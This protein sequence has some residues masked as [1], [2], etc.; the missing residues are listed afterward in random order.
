MAAIW[1]PIPGRL[2]SVS[3]ADKDNIWGV[4]LDLQL[5]KFNSK[6][7][8]WQLVSVTTEKINR[9]RFSSSSAQS[10]ASTTSSSFNTAKKFASYLP[11]LGLTSTTTPVSSPPATTTAV[12]TAQKTHQRNASTGSTAPGTPAT[13]TRANSSRS[14]LGTDT[15]EDTTIRVSAA[16]DGTV[17]RLD[18]SLKAWYLIA[19]HNDYVDYEKDVIWIDLGHFWK[20]VSGDIYYGTSGCFA[21]LEH[22]ITSGAGYSKPAFTHISVGNDNVVL[23]TDAHTGTVFRLK[24]HPTGSCPPVWTALTGTGPGSSLHILNCSISTT[25][26]IV[27]VAKDGRVYRYS[28]SVWTPLGGGAKL[29]NVG[30]GIDGYVLGVDRD[31][32]LFGCQLESIA[33]T[34]PPLN[35]DRPSS[36]EWTYK[37]VRDDQPTTPSSPQAPN[38]PSLF[39][40]PRQQGMSKRPTFSPRELFE[41]AASSTLGSPAAA[42][43][44]DRSPGAGEL[45]VDTTSKNRAPSPLGEVGRGPSWAQSHPHVFAKGPG[46]DRSD[47]R[48]SKRSYASDITI[49]KTPTGLSLSR[50]STPVSFRVPENDIS[51]S[52]T[53]QPTTTTTTT[54]ITPEAAL[55]VLNQSRA[56]AS[57]LRILTK[58]MPISSAASLSTGHES[59]SYFTSKPITIIGPSSNLSPMTSFPLDGNPYATGSKPSSGHSTAQ[60]PVTPHSSDSYNNNNAILSVSSKSSDSSR[61]WTILGQQTVSPEETRALRQAEQEEGVSRAGNEPALTAPLSSPPL[62]SAPSYVPEGLGPGAEGQGQQQQQQQDVK[63]KRLEQQRPSVTN[64]ESGQGVAPL[65]NANGG[66]TVDGRVELAG[67]NEDR[68]YHREGD[69]QPPQQP[70][71]PLAPTTPAAIMPFIRN[72]QFNRLPSNTGSDKDEWIENAIDDDGGGDVGH[73][74]APGGV[75]IASYRN[76]DDEH[77]W[78]GDAVAIQSNRDQDKREPFAP[79][80]LR[81]ESLQSPSTTVAPIAPTPF[82]PFISRTSSPFLSTEGQQGSTPAFEQQ[83][84]QNDFNIFANGQ[85]RTASFPS[86]DNNTKQEL[87]TNYNLYPTSPPD[88]QNVYP[89]QQNLHSQPESPPPLLQPRQ[90]L[91]NQHRP[92]DCSEVLMLQQQEFLRQ[93]RLRSQP[94][95]VVAGN[96]PVLNSFSASPD[97]AEVHTEGSYFNSNGGDHYYNSNGGDHYY[98]SN[99]GNHY[100]NN[101]NLYNNSNLDG[102][103]NNQLRQIGQQNQQH[104][105]QY[106]D[107]L[108]PSPP[109]P[110][111]PSDYINNSNNSNN[112]NDSMRIRT[113]FD[114]KSDKDQKDENR[115]PS[116][117][118]LSCPTSPSPS[119]YPISQALDGEQQQ[120]QVQHQQQ[121]Q[122]QQQEDADAPQRPS[123]SE[124]HLHHYVETQVINQTTPKMANRQS[125]VFRSAVG[126]GDNANGAGIGVGRGD[127][128]GGPTTRRRG[129][130][131][132]GRRGSSSNSNGAT[133]ATT[134]TLASTIASAGGIQGEDAQGRWIGSP[135][136]VDQRVVTYPSEIHK[137]RCCIIQ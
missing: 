2:Q 49:P 30:V 131:P 121:H 60:T 124:T 50:P 90:D 122:Q 99:G 116:L 29:D 73:D 67:V 133:N 102:N 14:L 13:M 11:S 18:R 23:A 87:F 70:Y 21:P 12:M 123:Y 93:T 128:S 57:P 104:F 91:L 35:L 1:H 120:Q 112:D 111:Q 78:N 41:M 56:K 37:A 95:S 65:I 126:V 5:C 59:E 7:Q 38:G 34:V 117:Y 46:L 115:R 39:N 113:R 33:K 130:D 106:Q 36:R 44:R 125:M 105:Q 69:T 96:D 51:S 84:Q 64:V 42:G 71:Q 132:Y 58:G 17:V 62:D 119:T 27:A 109:P 136:G 45:R 63:D 107:V 31:G 15:E 55:P 108:P 75:N 103:G 114:K 101:H 22:A 81:N 85:P 80:F 74:G 10:S 97:K 118:I 8:Q 32:D 61:Q 77:V 48:M 94:S 16:S 28:H 135:T 54:T 86:W 20:C 52:P 72:M 26:F 76:N 100:Y 43:Q 24:L 6:Q 92:S 4:T 68:D 47:S 137:S 134:T 129:N 53:E 25:D 9:A 89:Q 3:V 40:A 83:Q 19:P 82:Q 79:Q 88:R 98:N 127:P 66:T 110:P